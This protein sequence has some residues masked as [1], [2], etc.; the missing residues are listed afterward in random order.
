MYLHILFSGKFGI[1]FD[2]GLADFDEIAKFNS[3][4]FVHEALTHILNI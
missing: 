3:I 1:E 2:C 4:H